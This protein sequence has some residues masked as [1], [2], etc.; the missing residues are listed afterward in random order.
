MWFR[1]WGGASAL[2]GTKVV[3]WGRPRALLGIE[4]VV[5]GRPSALL[6]I[7]VAVWGGPTAWPYFL[8]PARTAI[9]SPTVTA[10]ALLPKELRT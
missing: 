4:V 5:W 3:V 8:F 2:L 6:G 9:T 1:P 7:E 10:L